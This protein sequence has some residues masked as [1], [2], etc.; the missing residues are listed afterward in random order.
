MLHKAENIANQGS[1]SVRDKCASF[2]CS[3]RI[4]Q[5]AAL[6]VNLLLDEHVVTIIPGR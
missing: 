5:R 1:V 2:V 3:T 4:R 6:K